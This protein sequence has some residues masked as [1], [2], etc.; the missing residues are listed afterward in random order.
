MNI[1]RTDWD[2][3]QIATFT[4]ECLKGMQSQRSALNDTATDLR[5]SGIENYTPQLKE[6]V[7]KLVL[8]PENLYFSQKVNDPIHLEQARYNTP[9]EVTKMLEDISR[10]NY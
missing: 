5:A 6:E 4:P 2:L 7:V 8:P 3:V 1:V 10:A 9:A